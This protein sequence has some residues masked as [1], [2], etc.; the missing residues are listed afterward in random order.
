MHIVGT[1]GHATTDDCYVSH[2][3][4]ATTPPVNTQLG[5]FYLDTVPSLYFTSQRKE[6][7]LDNGING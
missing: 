7:R 5:L 4:Q 6:I 1:N 3:G 2:A